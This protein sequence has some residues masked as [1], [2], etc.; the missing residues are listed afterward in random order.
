[1]INLK[2]Y[3]SPRNKYLIKNNNH[4]INPNRNQFHLVIY[5]IET[6]KIEIIV[7]KLN[8]NNSHKLLNLYRKN[9]IMGSTVCKCVCPPGENL[10]LE[11]RLREL[12]AN[13]DN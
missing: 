10:R 6:N 7:R 3:I 2:K 9:S 4:I 12:R 5:Y 11:Q 8:Q 13:R 1:M